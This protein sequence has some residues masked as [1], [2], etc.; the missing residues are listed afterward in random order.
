MDSKTR[1]DLKTDKFAQEVSHTFDFLSTHTTDVKKYGA[2]AVAIL[3]LAA[4]VYY[5]MH[6]QAG[7][8]EAALEK[9]YKI[10]N[11]VVG[12][13]A[14]PPEI[15]FP[16]AEAKDEAR[17]KAFSELSTKYHG[18]LEGAVGAIVIASN[19]VNKGKLD[20]AEKI[21]KDLMDSAPAG[22]ASVARL[23]LADI[24][25]SQGKMAEAEKLLRDLM[26]NPTPLVSKEQA[27]VALGS[28][29]TKSNPTE[30]RKLLEP[31]RIGRTAI[32]KAAIN[33]LGNLPQNN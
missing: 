4:G 18:T 12:P 30:A 11:A 22:Y 27:Q 25:A 14:Q 13:N 21:Y 28:L 10:D 19:N 6:Y 16:T 9:A 26:S 23:A 24:W 8:R 17:L 1:K 5:Y 2:V 33:A 31:L 29:L 3:L 7:V 32:S 20:E 15:N